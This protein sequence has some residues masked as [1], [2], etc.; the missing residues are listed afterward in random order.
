MGVGEIQCSRSFSQRN[1]NIQGDERK[2]AL[3]AGT[4]SQELITTPLPPF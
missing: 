4:F 1:G 3:R 2:I